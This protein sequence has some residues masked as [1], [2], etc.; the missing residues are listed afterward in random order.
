MKTVQK[1]LSQLLQ[2]T[3]KIRYP[4]RSTNYYTQDMADKIVRFIQKSGLRRAEAERKL[5]GYAL[6]HQ[7]EILRHQ[8]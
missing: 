8:F 2:E 3:E 7:D 1:S 5:I 6:L 4:V